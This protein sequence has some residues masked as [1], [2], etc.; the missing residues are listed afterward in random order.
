MTI[1]VFLIALAHAIPVFIAGVLTNSRVVLTIAAVVMTLVAIETGD[2]RYAVF[3]LLAVGLVYFLCYSRIRTST[4]TNSPR[5]VASA[6]PSKTS[7]SRSFVRG[8]ALV[9]IVIFLY[10]TFTDKPTPSPSSQPPQPALTQPHA[11]SAAAPQQTPQTSKQGDTAPR[12][13]ANWVKVGTEFNGITG[14]AEQ[15]TIR[16]SGGNAIMWD[17]MDFRTPRKDPHGKP[18]LSQMNQR[19]YDCKERKVRELYFSVHS[20]NMGNGV[21]DFSKRETR[22][23]A[24]IVSGKA[25]EA[26]LE[27]ACSKPQSSAKVPTRPQLSFEDVSRC[28]WVYAPIVQTGR[29]FPHDELFQFAQARMVWFDAFLKANQGN[30]ALKTVFENGITQYKQ[31]GL[32]LQDSLQE[33]L[34]TNNGRIFASVMDAAVS[35]DKTLGIRTQ[36][37]P[38]M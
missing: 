8:L 3:D 2:A 21:I 26:M 1:T 11:V 23:W 24:P 29:D 36:S 27:V 16:R 17:L 15:T 37:I 4:A 22:E 14:Y 38:R 7:Y 35:C 13:R 18:F 30:P 6:A 10:I 12:V 32:R 31:A 20:E 19:E 34:S 5:T 9:T 28:F 33:A 25:G